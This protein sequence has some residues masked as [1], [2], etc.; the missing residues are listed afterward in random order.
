[1]ASAATL[2][3]DPR[4]LVK[5]LADG[6]V[7]VAVMALGDSGPDALASITT[8]AEDIGLP[9]APCYTV[10]DL[11]AHTDSTTEGAIASGAL[12]PHRVALLRVTAACK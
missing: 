6:A 10:R 8:T 3:N 11:W 9:K 1:M 2:R 4:V 5:P 12:A 7:A